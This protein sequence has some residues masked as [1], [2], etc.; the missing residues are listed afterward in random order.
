M[1]KVIKF[2]S[3]SKQDSSNITDKSINNTNVKQFGLSDF[4]M[5]LR[6]A[7]ED[8]ILSTFA[9]KNILGMDIVF[10]EHKS[11]IGILGVVAYEHKRKAGT[12]V[13]NFISEA[14]NEKG[15]VR[16]IEVAFEAGEPDLYRS[17]YN[18]L[19]AKKILPEF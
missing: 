10:K 6:K 19:K 16:V 15:N 4:E 11:N 1:G 3:K 14:V 13:A 12:Y 18:T 9:V 8:Y 17:I 2:Q 5:S 7:L